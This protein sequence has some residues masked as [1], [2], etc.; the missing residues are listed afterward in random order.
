MEGMKFS[1]ETKLYNKVPIEERW[2]NTGEATITTQW[3]DISKGDYIAPKCR[4][5]KV[6]REVVHKKHGG[7]SAANPPIEADGEVLLDNITQTYTLLLL[8]TSYLVVCVAAIIRAVSAV[9]TGQSFMFSAYVFP[10][11]NGCAACRDQNFMFSSGAACVCQYDGACF[12][13]AL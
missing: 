1:R 4:S 13:R 3:M 11:H 6:P 10:L 2:A 9:R 12:V 8:Y 5:R 7:L